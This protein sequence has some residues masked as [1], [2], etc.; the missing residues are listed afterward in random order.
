[1]STQKKHFYNDFNKELPLKQKFI[2]LLK[3]QSE[4]YNSP[5]K[6]YERGPS[7]IPQKIYNTSV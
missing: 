3:R 1:M 2:E 6:K 4:I 7:S 5:Y